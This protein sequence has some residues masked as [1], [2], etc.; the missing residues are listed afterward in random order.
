MAVMIAMSVKVNANSIMVK[1]CR[2]VPADCLGFGLMIMPSALSMKSA[3][4][5]AGLNSL[6]H[7]RVPALPKQRS[8]ANYRKVNDFGTMGF[9]HVITHSPRELDAGRV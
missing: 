1:P 2:S 6:Q 3:V 8:Q 7:Q 9:A 5:A 4:M